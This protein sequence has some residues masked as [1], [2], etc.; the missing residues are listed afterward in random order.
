MD[1]TQKSL[2][3]FKLDYD[4]LEDLKKMKENITIF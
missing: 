4:V 1:I 3:D 2:G